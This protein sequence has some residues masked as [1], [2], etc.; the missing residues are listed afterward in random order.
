MVQRQALIRSASG[1]TPDGLPFLYSPNLS[2]VLRHH[3]KKAARATFH[4]VIV[5]ARAGNVEGQ[6]EEG[7]V[8]SKGGPT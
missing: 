7:E 2:F 3:T 5:V 4:P 1:S 6:P 8:G